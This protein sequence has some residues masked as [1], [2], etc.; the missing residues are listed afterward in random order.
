MQQNSHPGEV[1]KWLPPPVVRSHLI[2]H[3]LRKIPNIRPVLSNITK[4]PEQNILMG[5]K[6][7]VYNSTG[8]LQ[9][10]IMN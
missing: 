5:L 1:D 9:F 7:H 2:Q 6:P 3:A 4:Q 10:G 8:M